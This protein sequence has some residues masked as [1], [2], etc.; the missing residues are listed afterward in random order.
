M[1]REIMYPQVTVQLTGQ[2]G[3]AFAIITRVRAAI[4]V[5]VGRDEGMAW[6]VGAMM[7]SSYDELLALAMETVT[8]I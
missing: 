3:N 8:V 2:D 1:G 5:T 7:C 4:D 6:Q